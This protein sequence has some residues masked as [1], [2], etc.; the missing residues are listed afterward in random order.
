MMVRDIVIPEH[1]QWQTCRQMLQYGTCARN[2]DLL[3]EL[4]PESVVLSTCPVVHYPEMAEG[5][6]LL[7]RSLQQL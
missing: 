1:R 2:D 6:F 7:Y 3:R 4:S 5:T